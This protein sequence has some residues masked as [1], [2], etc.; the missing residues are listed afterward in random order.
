MRAM[1]ER[2]RSCF[3]AL[4]LGSPLLV[5]CGASAYVPRPSPRI[6][7]VTEGSSLSLVKNGQSYP[8]NMFGGSLEDVVEG[9]PRAEAEAHAYRNKTVAG[10]VFSTVGSVSAGVGAGIL[11]GDELQSTPSNSLLI[12]SLVMTLGGL[13]L[14]IVGGV[15]GGSAQPHLWNA[16]NLYNDGLPVAYPVWQGQ[17]AYP[18]YR[19]VPGA[20]PPPGPFPGIPLS[21]PAP[22]PSTA[23]LPT[24]AA[25]SYVPA[26]GV[27]PR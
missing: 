27:M 24:P 3:A 1:N 18:G 7:V 10:F 25:S 22:G 5:G 8:F 21:A 26:P 15:I 23:P 11:V 16:I 4:L 6:Q 9:N 12:G 14:S 13:A 2:L 17:P 20:S 19:V